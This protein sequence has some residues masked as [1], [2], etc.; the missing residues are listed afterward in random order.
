LRTKVFL[1]SAIEINVYFAL[2]LLSTLKRP[3]SYKRLGI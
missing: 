3:Q 1:Q 2:F